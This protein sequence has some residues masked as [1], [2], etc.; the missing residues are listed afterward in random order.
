MHHD[1]ELGNPALMLPYLDRVVAGL[2]A[3]AGEPAPVQPDHARMA[4]LP[5]GDRYAMAPQHPPRP[6]SA[7]RATSTVPFSR[8]R[9]ITISHR[10]H[11]W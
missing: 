3:K 10:I 5:A 8:A 7:Q 6:I 9:T 4:E 11:S 2:A 1:Y